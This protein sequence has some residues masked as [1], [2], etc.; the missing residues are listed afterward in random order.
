VDYIK[1]I[2]GRIW[3]TIKSAFAKLKEIGKAIWDSIKGAFSDLG[4]FF[5]RVLIEPLGRAIEDMWDAV[6]KHF[7]FGGRVS[8]THRLMAVK[9]IADKVGSSDVGGLAAL[10]EKARTK[11]TVSDEDIKSIGVTDQGKIKDLRDVLEAVKNANL[12]E[13]FNDKDNFEKLLKVAEELGKAG[14]GNVKAIFRSTVQTPQTAS[15][16]PQR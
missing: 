11:Q 4:A 15:A 10:L 8:D 13:D 1:S 14:K 2:P 3:E 7:G 5:N 12:K 9:G 6:K 16:G